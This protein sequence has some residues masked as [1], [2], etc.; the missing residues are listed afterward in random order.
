M[1]YTQ[2]VCWFPEGNTMWWYEMSILKGIQGFGALM[3]PKISTL[4]QPIYV[5]F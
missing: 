2:K 4:P 3:L 5:V 1:H